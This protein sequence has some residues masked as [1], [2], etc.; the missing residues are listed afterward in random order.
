MRTVIA[1]PAPTCA[2]LVAAR[3]SRHARPSQRSPR[4]AALADCAQL[5]AHRR[6]VVARAGGAHVGGEII[7]V[8]PH[9]KAL[10]NALELEALIA[11]DGPSDYYALLGLPL[12]ADDRAVREAYRRVP[13]RSAPRAHARSHVT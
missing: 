2:P 10:S 9:F 1:A 11:T 4:T 6:S 5:T 12:E 8:P 13:P 3:L 7:I